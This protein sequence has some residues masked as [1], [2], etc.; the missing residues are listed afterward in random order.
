MVDTGWSVQYFLWRQ[1]TL[2][3]LQLILGVN[4]FMLI[5]G[6]LLKSLLVDHLDASLEGRDPEPPS[7]T[8]LLANAYGVSRM[9]VCRHCGASSRASASASQ[10]YLEH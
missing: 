7:W 2:N 4:F 6:V 3:D 1:S 8:N 5:A 10:D 9:P